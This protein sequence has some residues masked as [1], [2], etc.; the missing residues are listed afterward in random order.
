MAAFAFF[1]LSRGATAN[2]GASHARADVG[3][4]SEEMRNQ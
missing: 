1:I 2:V 4:A 3:P